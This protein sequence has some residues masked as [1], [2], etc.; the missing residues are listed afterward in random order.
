M[1]VYTVTKKIGNTNSPT[2]MDYATLAGWQTDSPADLTTAE[3]SL[4]G[5]FSGA[6]AQA[7]SLTFVGSGA[8]GK[9]LETDGSTYIVYGL[10]TGNP[11]ASDVVTGGTSGKTCVLSSSTPTHVGVIWSGECYDQGTF[12]SGAGG[13]ILIISGQT[14]SATCYLILQCAAGASFGMKSGVRTTALAYDNTKG[15]SIETSGDNLG[16]RDVNA[17]STIKGIQFSHNGNYGGFIRGF[18]LSQNCI[19]KSIQGIPINPDDNHPNSVVDNCLIISGVSGVTSGKYYNCTIIRNGA[20]AGTALAANYANYLKIVNCAIFNFTT[21]KTASALE[22]ASDYNATDLA[23]SFGVG[24]HNVNSLTYASQFVS[25]SDWRAVSS[26]GL[27]AGTPDS[28]NAPLDISLT[29]RDG[30]TPYIGAWEVTA[31][32]APRAP[33]GIVVLQPDNFINMFN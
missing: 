6:F 32:A 16:I 3:R 23:T 17:T 9:L 5:T 29:A 8:T 31:A 14:T 2:T 20:A 27:K 11:A 19:I 22:S 10:I 21:L 12:A 28:T 18:L 30:T 25:S 4:A 7:E 26:G 24:T 15:V 33:R 1:A 13:N